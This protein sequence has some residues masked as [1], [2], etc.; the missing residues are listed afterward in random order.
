M[1]T[2]ARMQAGPLREPDALLYMETPA[3]EELLSPRRHHRRSP[4]LHAAHGTKRSLS[5]SC[6]YVPN[7]RARVHLLTVVATADFHPRQLGLTKVLRWSDERVDETQDQMRAKTNPTFH[8]RIHNL[9][10]CNQSYIGFLELLGF[11]GSGT[12]ALGEDA[13]LASMASSVTGRSPKEPWAILLY[14]PRPVLGYQ[15]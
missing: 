14:V 3:P 4:G 2:T 10:G 13:R 7:D 6:A 9:S 8:P 12:G 5:V 11:S 1:P 15:C